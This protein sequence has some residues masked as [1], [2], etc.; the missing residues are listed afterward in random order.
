MRMRPVLLLTISASTIAEAKMTNLA[1]TIFSLSNHNNSHEKLLVLREPFHKNERSFLQ[2]LCAPHVR[3]N[4]RYVR[5]AVQTDTA[6]PT[7]VTEIISKSYLVCNPR[8]HVLA[9]LVLAQ[10][11]VGRLGTKSVTRRLRPST[12]QPRKTGTAQKC[13]RLKVK[14][15]IF[16]L[17]MSIETR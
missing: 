2:Q 17:F 10:Q 11:F 9:Y 13:F 1:M 15:S 12:R 3:R 4:H 7:G 16:L 6:A 14:P 8:S 5:L